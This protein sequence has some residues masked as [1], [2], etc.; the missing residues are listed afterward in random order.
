MRELSA[1]PPKRP[2]SATA[3]DTLAMERGLDR[4]VQVS[5][6]GPGGDALAFNLQDI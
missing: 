4:I 3:A 2:A 6:L 1:Q 5:F